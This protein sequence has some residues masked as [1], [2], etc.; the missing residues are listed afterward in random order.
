MDPSRIQ[1]RTVLIAEIGV[2]HNGSLSLAKEL[3]DR[4]V[5]AGADYAKFQTFRSSQVATDRAESAQYQRDGGAGERQVELLSSLELSESSFEELAS[6]CEV[7]GIGFLTTAHDLTSANFV[8]ELRLDFLKVSSGDITNFP[9]LRLYSE[10]GTP[11]LLSTGA[12]DA[13]EVKRAIDVLESGGLSRSLIT[14]LQC[15]S[16]YPAP[17]SEANLSAMVTMREDW[18][19]A[20]GYSDHTAGTSLAMAAV[21]LGASVIEKHIT[22]DRAMVGPDHQASL[23]PWE[24]AEMVAGIRQVEQGLGGGVK[25]VMPS[26]QANRRLIRKSIVAIE[27]IAS[28]QLF[29]HH[30]LGVMRPDNGLS[31]IEWEQVVGQRARR[32][33][34]VHDLIEFP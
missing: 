18:N 2:N 7:R 5:E 19:V 11:V 28:G 4:C 26:E 1:K 16:A 6:Y 30:N 9:L 34:E 31:A 24:F 17:A 27:P 23:E 25:V 3:V 20:V 8:T 14:V 12:S 33:Y 29:A 13:N 10:Q 15:T 32:D 21:A 22:I